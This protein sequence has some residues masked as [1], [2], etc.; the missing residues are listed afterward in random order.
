M[1][2]KNQNLRSDPR[3]GSRGWQK[4]E[5]GCSYAFGDDIVNRACEFKLLLFYYFNY[6]YLGAELN[7]D[8]IIR[9]HQVVQGNSE[10]C[11]IFVYVFL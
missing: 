1:N 11:F 10:F 7:L 4:S 3:P 9:A 8:M 6:T 2:S 5:R